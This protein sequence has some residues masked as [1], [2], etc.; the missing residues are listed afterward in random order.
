MKTFSTTPKD[1]Q[2]EWYVVD[3]EGQTLGRLASEI[4]SILRG[5]NKPYFVPHLDTGDYVIV[6]NASEIQVTGNKMDQK[7]YT[8]YTGWPGGLRTATLRERMA[9]HPEEVVRGAIKGM[10]PRGPLGRQ[11][12]RKLHVYAHT[13]HPHQAQQPKPLELDQ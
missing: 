4:A 6:V 5:K 9:K 8:R 11:M 3:A 7:V 1:I 12:L 2:R 10:L 13:D